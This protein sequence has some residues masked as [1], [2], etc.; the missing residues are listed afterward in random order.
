MTKYTLLFFV[1]VFALSLFFINTNS[2][3]AQVATSDCVIT[4]TLRLGSTGSE[5]ACLQ[6]QL[7]IMVDG[8]FGPNR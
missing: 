4:S 6:S 5:V 1:F 2:V 7:G 3:E 8:K